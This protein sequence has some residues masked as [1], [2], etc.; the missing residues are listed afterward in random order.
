[1]RLLPTLLA[2]TLVSLTGCDDRR[3]TMPVPVAVGGRCKVSVGDSRS[4]VRIRCGGPC[5]SGVLAEGTCADG[6][7]GCENQCDVY[8][9]VE[10]CYLSDR[11]VALLSIDR[12]FGHFKWCFWPDPAAEQQPRRRPQN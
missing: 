9:D 3:A 6:R 1:M 4:N 8:Q 2:A 10:V 5:G 11:V 12:E 7:D